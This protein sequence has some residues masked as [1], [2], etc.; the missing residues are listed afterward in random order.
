M[1][2]FGLAG[3]RFPAALVAGFCITGTLFWTL[4]SFTDHDFEVVEARNVKIDFTRQVVETPVEEK[5]REK[6]E[7]VVPENVDID[8][9]PIRDD[10]TTIDNKVAWTPTTVTIPTHDGIPM[11]RDMQA[12]PLV[13]INPTYPP[14]EAQRGIEGWVLVQ[15]DVTATGSVTN[16]I[17]VETMPAGSAFDDAATEAVAR[18]RYNPSVVN[19]QAVDRVGMQTII[20]FNLEDE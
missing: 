10:T 18:W 2:T 20:R 12:V 13:R 19:G 8:L 16:V 4:W 1:G 15:F 7:R 3:L 9:P 6:P 17:A 11:G 5:A 14:R